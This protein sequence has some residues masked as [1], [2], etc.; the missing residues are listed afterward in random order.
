MNLHAPQSIEAATELRMIAAVPL[1]IVSPRE[2]VPIVSVVQDTLVGANR[3]TR[4]NVLFTKKETM[5][6]LVHSKRWEGQLPPPVTTTPQPMWSGQQILSALLPPVSLQ[7][8]NSS[9]SDVDKKVPTS[10]NLVK[11][12]NGTILQGIL[13]KSVFSKQLIHIIYNDYGPDVTVD[14]LDSLQSMIAT[15][16]MNSGFSVGISDLIADQATNDEIAIAL[17]KLTKTIEEQILQVHTGLF[18]NSSGRSNQEEFEGKVLGTLNKAVGEAGKIGLKSLADTNRMTNMVKAGSKGSDVNVSQMIAT[19]GQQAIEGKR[20]P[21]GFQHRTLP[22]FKRFDDSAQAR[23]FITSS[24]IKG[25]QPDE[26]FFHAMSGRE[27]LIDTA[28]K[29]VTA[30]T[31]ISIQ[32][33]G[34]WR[35]IQ[36][37][38]WIDDLLTK[39]SNEV[40]HSQPANLELLHIPVNSVKIW[41]CDTHGVTTL[42]DIS[43]VTRHD[44]G[45]ILYRM[46]T[47]TKQ[48]VIVSANKS[49]LVMDIL[50]W[51]EKA[52]AEVRAGIDMVPVLTSDKEAVIPTLIESIEAIPVDAKYPKLYDLT[53]PSTLNFALAN[54]LIVRDTAD[55]GYMQRQ[56]RVALE[57]LITQHDGSVRDTNGNLLQIAYGED[58]INATKLENQ[59]LPLASMSDAEIAAYAAAPGAPGAEEYYQEMLEDRRILVEKVFLNKPQKNVRYPVHLD[60][61]ACSIKTQFNLAEDKG[62]VT[63]AAVLEAQKQILLRTHANN[64]LWGALIRYHLAPSRLISCGYTQAALDMLAEQIVLKHWAAWVE[65]GQPVGVI[66]AQSIG[67]PATQMST[68]YNSKI[69][70]HN[71]NLHYSGPIGAYIDKLLE[72][73]KVNVKTLGPDSVVLD[74]D[75]GD[76]IIGVSTDEKTSWLPIKQVSRHPANGGLV[77]VRTRTGRMTTATLSHSFLKRTST[78]IAPILGSDLKVGDRVPVA[79]KIPQVSNPIKTIT[80]GKTTFT[81]NKDFGWLCGM[82]LADGSLG[83]HS[84]SICKIIPM[85]ETNMREI[86]KPFGWTFRATHYRGAYGPGKNNILNSKD[87][88]DMLDAKFGHGSF[89]KFI[90][91][92]IF[93]APVDFIAGLIGGYFDG[94]GNISVERQHI[95]VSSRN[96]TLLRDINRLLGYCSLYGYMG[97]ETSIRIPDAVQYTLNIPKSLIKDF[98]ETIGLQLPEKAEALNQIANYKAALQNPQRSQD[99]LDKIPALGELIA[100]TGKLLALPGQSRNYGRWAKKE[101]IGRDTLLSYLPIFKAASDSLTDATLKAKVTA[102]IYLLESAAYSDVLWDEIVELKYHEDPHT[103]VYDFTVPGNDSFMVD[104]NILVHNTLNTFHLSGVASKSAMTRG[105]PRLKELLKATRNPKAVELTIPL[106]HDLRGKKEEARRVSKELEFT[107]LQDIVT[108]ARIYF[109]PRDNATLIAEDQ[110]WLAYLAAYENLATGGLQP[111]IA[112]DPLKQTSITE[113]AQ[114]LQAPSEPKSPWILRFELDREQMFNKNITMDDIAFI[115]RNKFNSDITSLYTDYNATRLVFR[116]R[117]NTASSTNAMDDLNILKSLQNKILS[118]TAIRG[119]PGLRAVNYQKVEDIV[120]LKDGKYSPA[121]QYIL[122]SDGS[123]FLDVLT[124]PD[125]DPT[126][127]ISSNVHDMFANLGIEATRATLYKEITTL[128]ADAGSSVNY[129]HVCILLDKMCHKG[130]T[131]SIDRYGINKNDIGPLAKMSFEQTEDIA[132]RAAIFGERDPVL[133]IS[134]KV[135]LGAPIKAGTAFSEILLDETAVIQFNETAPEQTPATYEAL[136]PFTDSE[137]NDA[138]YG[139]DDNGEC[140]TTNLRI[141]VSLPT[142]QLTQ[143]QEQTPLDTIT[144]DNEY[145]GVAIYE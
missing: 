65:P 21:N 91:A 113:P 118:C 77:E 28:V 54:G 8:A 46:T 32:E 63:P 142:T 102:N 97:K 18:E 137:I 25:L 16:L 29:S 48:S 98:Q 50:G 44:P 101:S 124:H 75:G 64:R 74:L 40:E 144:E 26:F 59:T 119:I 19:L 22:H 20:V 139:A 94:D 81:L 104:D 37:G 34:M 6:L 83:T 55:T 86:A 123:N 9:F 120:E 143:V 11:I 80:Q 62:D 39:S 114:P 126:K 41:T 67:E 27:G 128:F 106:R 53:I 66:A 117:L 17:N 85:V 31:E 69:T 136:A 58:G 76:A 138:L 109:D 57:D 130:R 12:L 3:F 42:A 36:I 15:F 78:G 92:D 115:L 82:Y 23:G 43:A 10:Q 30:D 68:H 95:R 127:I 56:I 110:D 122:I 135:M 108:V 133:G 2:S 73:N 134:A 93:H 24:Y 1:Q 60:R 13:D 99:M 100:E 45:A 116:I 71:K 131:M 84:V 4:P 105:V 140:S 70:I 5:N 145:E 33:N 14:F 51:V 107:L 90:H 141:P 38:P 49:L 88:R 96:E 7:M 132:L 121:E 111:V 87:L 89:E 47:A 79:K 52:P 112:H 35:T 103:F 125:V 129:R 61:L 72:E